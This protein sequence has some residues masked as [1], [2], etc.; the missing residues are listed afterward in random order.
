M[1]IKVSG[2]TVIDD[3]RNLTNLGS[4]LTVTQGGTGVTTATGNGSVVLSDSPTLSSPNLGAVENIT[5]TGGT[6]GQYLSTDGSGNLSFA[7]VSGGGFDVCATKFTGG[8]TI[9]P[10]TGN[11]NYF[12]IRS[13]SNTTVEVTGEITS[14]SFDYIKNG[15]HTLTFPSCFTLPSNYTRYDGTANNVFEG[16]QNIRYQLNFNK[17]NGNVVGSVN[18]ICRIDGDTICL[19]D[20]KFNCAC[21]TKTV[22]NVKEIRQGKGDNPCLPG[23]CFLFGQFEEN[24][25]TSGSK[26]SKPCQIADYV[27]CTMGVCSINNHNTTNQTDCNATA[28]ICYNGEYYAIAPTCRQSMVATLPFQCSSNNPGGYTCQT[29]AEMGFAIYRLNEKSDFELQHYQSA[30]AHNCAKLTART[31]GTICVP[32]RCYVCPVAGSNYCVVPI[33]YS[34]KCDAF[35]FATGCHNFCCVDG[36]CHEAVT[37]GYKL[38]CLLNGVAEQISCSRLK[39]CGMQDDENSVNCCGSCVLFGQA[40]YNDIP[41]LDERPQ[42]VFFAN[43]TRSCCLVVGHL[44]VSMNV[45]EDCQRCYETCPIC[46]R[47]CAYSFLCSS[48]G[49]LT[50]GHKILGMSSDHCHLAVQYKTC[51]EC[52]SRFG[53]LFLKN[54][55]T[56]LCGDGTHCR[57][58]FSSYN[59]KFCCI[60]QNID[61]AYTSRCAT[62]STSVYTCVTHD[63]CHIF[64]LPQTPDMSQNS[65]TSNCSLAAIYTK[66]A[67]DCWT[68]SFCCATNPYSTNRCCITIRD[69]CCSIA[70]FDPSTNCLYGG[71]ATECIDANIG[72]SGD[73]SGCGMNYNSNTYTWS[74]GTQSY[75]VDCGESCPAPITLYP[76]C[77]NG[78]PYLKGID[79]RLASDRFCICNQRVPIHGYYKI[80]DDCLCSL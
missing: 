11:G 79:P 19:W 28:Y 30:W 23:T 80:S 16:A 53:I 5:V 72:Y 24:R 34:L 3:S 67:A 10:D 9:N 12:F 51:Y 7:D 21:E 22:G 65:C 50:S 20:T 60:V 18:C 37:V 49:N 68:T 54:S 39:I 4:P 13:T 48:F 25:S 15:D 55:S 43:I 14:L 40:Y 29:T 59:P 64:T 58:L 8:G 62:Q 75:C 70:S 52:C 74:I 41:N 61:Q 77:S 66:C 33:G 63:L 6:T 31:S 26:Y 32:A 78:S 56:P 1:A 69:L 47:S 36:L 46:A 45:N 44:A 71:F 42:H 76:T 27:K 2:T 17:I 38:S 73:V 57:C 35:F